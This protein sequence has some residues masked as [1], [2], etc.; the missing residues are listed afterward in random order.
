MVSKF[1]I[2]TF[3][4][5]FG[6]FTAVIYK[7]VDTDKDTPQIFLMKLEGN[8]MM[9]TK[10]TIILMTMNQLT[11]MTVVTSAMVMMMTMMMTIMTMVMTVM[12][13]I[14]M[15]VTMVTVARSRKAVSRREHLR[16]WRKTHQ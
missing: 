2:D 1:T 12:V 4:N 15:I 8:W 16:T 7:F 5:I 6:T 14:M 9:I 10:N 13:N 3:D 11:M